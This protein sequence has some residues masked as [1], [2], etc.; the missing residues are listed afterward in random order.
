MFYVVKYRKPEKNIKGAKNTDLDC[1]PGFKRLINC[2]IYFY[3]VCLKRDK[4]LDD[5]GYR[6]V[7][8]AMVTPALKDIQ[9]FNPRLSVFY[10]KT[11]ELNEFGKRKFAIMS[12]VDYERYITRQAKIQDKIDEKRGE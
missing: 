7:N 6:I 1:S 11:K 9:F 10:I 4:K 12:M 2:E 8:G 5:I 3:G